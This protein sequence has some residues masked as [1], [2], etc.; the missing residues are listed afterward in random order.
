MSWL[1]RLGLRAHCTG[2]TADSGRTHGPDG[3]EL[4]R[5]WRVVLPA[6]RAEVARQRAARA[7][8]RWPRLCGVLL[9]VLATSVAIGAEYPLPR[10]VDGASSAPA[11]VDLEP[12][13]PRRTRSPVPAALEPAG[14]VAGLPPR[15]AWD[16]AGI[17]PPFAV[18][19]LDAA[20]F[21]IARADGIEDASAIPPRG[22][23][24]ALAE[25]GTFH[26]YIEAEAAGRRLR[27]PLQTF[28]VR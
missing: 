28:E 4:R 11:S 16:P 17:R 12:K 9:I 14:R 27:S 6:V 5:P 21:E 2:G 23:A 8:P 3:R 20:Y 26:W 13:P 15:F 25:G 24:A 18:V 22:F 1:A 10:R 7:Q 19:L